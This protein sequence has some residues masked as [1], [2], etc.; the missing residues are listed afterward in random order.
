MLGKSDLESETSDRETHP[1]LHYQMSEEQPLLR[2]VSDQG[3][4]GHVEPKH[5]QII[6]FCTL[7]LLFICCALDALVSINITQISRELGLSPGVEL[8]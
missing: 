5:G 6:M 3:T 2:S 7:F 4:A 1:D 8:W